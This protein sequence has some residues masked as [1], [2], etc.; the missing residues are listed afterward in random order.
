[1]TPPSG[2]SSQVLFN[3]RAAAVAVLWVSEQQGLTME[4][5]GPTR[6]IIGI[7]AIGKMLN[8]ELK[9]DFKVNGYRNKD[10]TSL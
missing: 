4:E 9:N 2:W 8:Y 10:K 5:N 6:V 3:G 7:M 1:M